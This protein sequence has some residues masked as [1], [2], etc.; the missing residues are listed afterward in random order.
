[1]FKSFN[2]AVAIKELLSGAER[3]VMQFLQS[4]N[5]PE[6]SAKLIVERFGIV[7]HYLKPA[8]FCRTFGPERTNDHMASLLD[9]MLYGTNIGSPLVH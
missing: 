7:T 9:R 5:Q 6:A 4:F 8:A 2:A 1:M 3:R